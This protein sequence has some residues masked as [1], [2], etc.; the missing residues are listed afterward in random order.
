MVEIKPFRAYR[1]RKDLAK[2]VASLPYD[3]LS[4]DE[5]RRLAH[6]NSFSFYHINKPEI[7]LPEETDPYSPE[8]YTK[9]MENFKEFVSDGVL[10]RDEAP[11]FYIYRQRMG[12]HIQ[13]GIVAGASVEEYNKGLIKKHELTRPDKE[14]DRVRHIKRLEVQVGPVFLTYYSSSDINEIVNRICKREP[15][16]NFES[17]DGIEHILWVVSD[18]ETID[19]IRTAFSKVPYLYV[20]DGHHR[21]ASA[22]RIDCKRFLTVT[23][24]HDQMCIMAYNRVVKDLNGMSVDEFLNRVKEEFVVRD[25]S[26]S[27]PVKPKSFGMFL[28]GKWYCV[29]PKQGTYDA[30]D[31]VNA[32]DVA[33]LQNNLLSPILGIKNP[34]LDKRIDF[35]G[36]IRGTDELERR[37]EDGWAVAFC[38]YPTSIEELMNVADAGLLMP[39]KSTWFEPKLRSGLF[40]MGLDEE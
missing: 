30:S 16:Y 33:I 15:E 25:T 31:P 12:N 19:E 35:V 23:F 36:G 27:S 22:S 4:S 8:V 20:A 13:T 38:C 37:V 21:S 14:D 18:S 34:R 3:V 39:P 1:P 11:C 2:R 17:D 24:P 26:E 32:L 28:D 40:V 5:A 9:G 6:D 29:E 7:D 10:L